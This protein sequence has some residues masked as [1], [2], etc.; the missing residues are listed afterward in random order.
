MVP[1]LKNHPVDV[2]KPARTGQPLSSTSL[3]MYGAE[4]GERVNIKIGKP[5][6]GLG[7][8]LKANSKNPEEQDKDQG[9]D[10]LTRATLLHCH[11]LIHFFYH[12]DICWV[13]AMLLGLFGDETGTHQGSSAEDETKS[14]MGRIRLSPSPQSK[15]KS[16]EGKWS[17][18]LP[19]FPKLN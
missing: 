17:S 5:K 19:Q 7:L 11:S 4:V 13:P 9:R 16:S 18:K 6:R 2:L 15:G 12:T 8:L 10:D 1:L 3:C 14:P